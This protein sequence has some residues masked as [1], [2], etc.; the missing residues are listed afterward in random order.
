MDRRRFLT[1]I[2]PG[3]VCAVAGCTSEVPGSDDEEYD[4][5]SVESI[6]A[7]VHSF[8]GGESLTLTI[9][10]RLGEVLDVHVTRVDGDAS[11]KMI[12]MDPDGTVI[13]ET[14]PSQRVDQRVTA[15]TDGD[16][17]IKLI[18]Q[19]STERGEW[20]LLVEFRQAD[21]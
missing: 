10:L 8:A 16:Y 3:G 4:Q 20:E 12:V 17:E 15:G 2:V 1:A 7:E 9:D 11:P 14:D 6:V 13:E 19:D 18:N 21:C 5:C